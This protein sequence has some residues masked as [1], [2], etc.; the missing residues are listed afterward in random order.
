MRT[1][2]DYQIFTH[3]TFGGIS[4]YFAELAEGLMTLEQQVQVFAPL[5]RNSYLDSLPL[6]LVCGRRVSRYPLKTAHFFLTYNE[7]VSRRQM[8]KWKPEIVHQTFYCGRSVAP[9]GCPTVITVFDMIHELFT[10]EIRGGG[11]T[12]AIEKI[13]VDRA[14]HVICISENTKKDLM[15]IYGTPEE[16][17]SVVLLGFNQFD[18]NLHC[19]AARPSVVKPFC[20]FVGSR[21]GYKN[22]TGMLKAVAASPR[23]LADFNIIAFGGSAFSGAEQSLIRSLGF[24]ANQVQ[25]IGGS[26]ALLGDYYRTAR[27]FVY[28][29]LYEGFGIPPLEAM[30]HNC[31]VISSNTS[32]MPEVVG[33]AGEYFD[34]SD[35]G[36]FCRAIEAVVYSE[37]RVQSLKILG[38]ARL[39]H[40]SWSKCAKETLDIYQALI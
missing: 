1:A 34:P 31:P 8:A 40:F 38:A 4:R 37:S 20:L 13:A 39:A 21:G 25:Q 33:D 27:A 7:L 24:S 32:S 10:D 15:Q 28:P 16:K 19:S 30:A 3:Q 11:S 6:E 14:D 2:F 22:F 23:L 5:H 17:I 36:D 12:V 35:T 26:D 29:S 9:L 18:K